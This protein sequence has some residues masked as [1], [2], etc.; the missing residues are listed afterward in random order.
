MQ[1]MGILQGT[2][3][4]IRHHLAGRLCCAGIAAF[5]M[6]VISSMVL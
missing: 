6:Y 4:G 5:I 2:G 1:T 3:I